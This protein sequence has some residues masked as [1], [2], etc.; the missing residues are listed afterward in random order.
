MRASAPP[1]VLL[2]AQH[3][4]VPFPSYWCHWSQ[5]RGSGVPREEVQRT[6]FS[7][8]LGHAII[9]I[10]STSRILSPS[11]RLFVSHSQWLSPW[12]GAHLV[13]TGGGGEGGRA[14]GLSEERAGFSQEEKCR[15]MQQQP[16]LSKLCS[17]AL[18][19]RPRACAR[20]PHRLGSGQAAVTPH[21][22]SSRPPGRV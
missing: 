18:S 4:L 17:S 21:V 11:P 12:S 14:A 8:P 1:T 9:T 19:C 3:H 6:S 15:L 2:T 20:R 7:P 16:A 10:I 22:L 13:M 5:D